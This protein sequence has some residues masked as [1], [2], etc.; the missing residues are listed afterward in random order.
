[1]TSSR[2]SP[3]KSS[4]LSQVAAELRAVKLP[5]PFDLKAVFLLLYPE[6]LKRWLD[7]NAAE[8]QPHVDHKMEREQKIG[9]ALTSR[10]REVV[11]LVG[12]GLK[13]R[14]IAQQLSISEQTVK[15]HL[16]N[17]F[18]KLGASN[19]HQATRR[20]THLSENHAENHAESH[21]MAVVFAQPD[22]KSAIR[23]KSAVNA[24]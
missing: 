9:T 3:L 18:D 11:G 15:N 8:A 20:F 6:A 22:S 17:I 14:E 7:S 10:E 23:A 24:G 16:Q 1:M 4:G 5:S 2:P 21:T 19:R 13:N 12:Q